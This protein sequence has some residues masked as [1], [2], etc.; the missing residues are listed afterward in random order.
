MRIPEV[1]SRLREIARHLPDREAR[2]L[3]WLIGE[4]KRRPRVRRAP[5]QS[6]RMTPVLQARLRR[7]AATHVEWSYQRIGAHFGV[8]AGRVSEALA[9]KRR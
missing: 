5:V 3:R 7:F 6:K 2:Q 8:N 9:G 4:L 1:R